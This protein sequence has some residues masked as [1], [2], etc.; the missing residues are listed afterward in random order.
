MDHRQT[1]PVFRFH[2]WRTPSKPM[3]AVQLIL[4]A[5]VDYVHK[6]G[7]GIGIIQQAERVVEAGAR[8][9]RA[10]SVSPTKEKKYSIK[11]ELFTAENVKTKER[12]YMLAL[13][14]A[15]GM[16]YSTI[17]K[18][19]TNEGSN[20]EDVKIATSSPAVVETVNHHIQNSSESLEY[21]AN[22]NDRVMIERVVR[23]VKKVFRRGVN[24][25]IT[26]ADGHDTTVARARANTL[27]RQRGRRQR[28]RAQNE[29]TTENPNET[30]IL[31]GNPSHP[32]LEVVLQQ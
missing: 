31:A 7:L 22:M 12:S 28:N 32:H 21:V 4:H 30:G 2:P 10:G 18:N 13:L 9:P 24:V 11:G 8:K 17:K 3:R 16:A 26:L 27:A 1:N 6:Q 14:H 15:L 25:S 19:G 29:G 20:V 23:A 5:E